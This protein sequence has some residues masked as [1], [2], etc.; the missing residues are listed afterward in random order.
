MSRAKR[1][2]GSIPLP[3]RSS[4]S[5]RFRHDASPNVFHKNAYTAKRRNGAEYF[6]TLGAFMA[7][8]ARDRGEDPFHVLADCNGGQ[9]PKTGQG[10]RSRPFPET[11]TVHGAFGVG[12]PPWSDPSSTPK[13]SRRAR[14][15]H[16]LHDG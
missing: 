12:A 1:P 5:V 4:R 6:I 8:W 16:A 2:A 11:G 14:G 13:K 7:E 10:R 9:I 15:V 3:G